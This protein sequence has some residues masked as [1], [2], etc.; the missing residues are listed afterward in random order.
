LLC[1]IVKHSFFIPP[2]LAVWRRT[3]SQTGEFTTGSY[4]RL[5]NCFSRS[6]TLIYDLIRKAVF[7]KLG[8]VLAVRLTYGLYCTRAAYNTSCRTYVAVL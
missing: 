8:S 2:V 6:V 5:E 7:F 3:T 1:C 4:T